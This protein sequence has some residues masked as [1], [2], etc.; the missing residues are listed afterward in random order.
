MYRTISE[1]SRYP[2]AGFVVNSQTFEIQNVD[3]DTPGAPV[4]SSPFHNSDTIAEKVED[5]LFV[6]Q[7]LGNIRAN[8]TTYMAATQNRDLKRTRIGM[9]L[10]RLKKCLQ[11][12][13]F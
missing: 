13:M 6:L 11:P 2:Q 12:D 1:W 3:L 4:Q 10:Q 8:R 5:S 9:N 7:L